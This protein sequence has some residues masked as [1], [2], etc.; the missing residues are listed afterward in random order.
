VSSRAAGAGRGLPQV[1]FFVAPGGP[2]GL[3]LSGRR[4]Q[5]DLTGGRR[6]VVGSLAARRQRRRL[7]GSLVRWLLALLLLL[8]TAYAYFVWPTPWVYSREVSRGYSFDTRVH[9]ISGKM[10]RRFGTRWLS[11]APAPGAPASNWR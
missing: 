11:V 2:E 9:R 8:G 1:A 10:E 6:E 3:D 4:E 5:G 7:L